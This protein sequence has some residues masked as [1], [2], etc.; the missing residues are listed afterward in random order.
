LPFSVSKLIEL[1]W[2]QTPTVS[3]EH[4]YL[5]SKRNK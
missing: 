2:R 3:K 5:V 1:F 4:K